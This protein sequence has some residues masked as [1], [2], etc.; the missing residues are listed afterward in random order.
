MVSKNAG[1]LVGFSRLIENDGREI[2]RT[3]NKL[4]VEAR[5]FSWGDVLSDECKEGWG[6]PQLTRTPIKSIFTICASESTT[7]RA[8]GS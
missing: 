2:A 3:P 6:E 1:P 7:T 8:M 4:S 5:G